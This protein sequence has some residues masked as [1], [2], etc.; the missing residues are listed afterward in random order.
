MSVNSN[1]HLQVGTANLDNAVK[2][3]GLGIESVAQLFQSGEQIVVDFG[4][5]GNVH[6]SREAV[7]ACLDAACHR[8][9][10]THVSLLL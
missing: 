2:L 3:F 6:N 1:T 7:D 8:K 4:N 9:C 5:G 10:T